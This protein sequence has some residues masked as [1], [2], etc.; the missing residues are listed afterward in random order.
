MIR[1]QTM[2]EQWLILARSPDRGAWSALAHLPPG[3]GVLVIQRLDSRQ[4]R[5]LRHL[6]Q[7]R[8]FTVVIE[9]RRTAARVHDIRELRQALL[10]R[11][12]LILLSPV[13][14]TRSHPDWI[15]LPGMRA[16]ALARLGCR[17][18]F[19]LGGMSARRYATIAPLGFVGWAGISAF[20]T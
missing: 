17:R 2:P 11:T 10:W 20:R 1:R 3:S 16:A 8:K 19:A 6:A 12:P 7:L 14:E 5:R 4:N 9:G 15:P 18:L 13:Y